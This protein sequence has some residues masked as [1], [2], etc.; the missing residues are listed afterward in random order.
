MRM[1]DQVNANT[2]QQLPAPP[3]LL[4]AEAIEQAWRNLT[5]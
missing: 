5:P 3:H 4:D 2:H 1:G